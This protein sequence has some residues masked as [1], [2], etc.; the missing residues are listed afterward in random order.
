MSQENKIKQILKSHLNSLDKTIQLLEAEEK[1]I[2]EREREVVCDLE[3]LYQKKNEVLL[4][5]S[6]SEFTAS[7]LDEDWD[8]NGTLSLKTKIL[9]KETHKKVPKM[10]E[11]WKQKSENHK[12]NK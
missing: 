6:G 9:S 10:I 3:Y 11:A 2:R 4:T 8:I 12:K 1:L 5:L 7:L